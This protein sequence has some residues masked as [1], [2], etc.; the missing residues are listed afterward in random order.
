[1]CLWGA[2]LGWMA[3]EKGGALSPQLDASTLRRYRRRNARG[4]LLTTALFAYSLA[5]ALL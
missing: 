5:M 3:A 4:A 2:L 1:M